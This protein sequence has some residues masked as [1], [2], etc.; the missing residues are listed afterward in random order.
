MHSLTGFDPFGLHHALNSAFWLDV[1]GISDLEQIPA[2]L[3][4]T[5][6]DGMYMTGFFPFMMFG[7]PAACIAMYQTAKPAK[8]KM[9][10]GLFSLQLSLFF[11]QVLQNQLSFPLCS[12]LQGC[13]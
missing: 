9:V 6:R 11:L 4:F 12:W 3:V 1:A 13:M 8:K 2:I 7:L 5:D 10:Y